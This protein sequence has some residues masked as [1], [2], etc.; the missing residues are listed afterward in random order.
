MLTAEKLATLPQRARENYPNTMFDVV[1][2]DGITIT[3]FSTFSYYEAKTYVKS[4][5]RSQTGALGNINN[6]ATFV[7][8]RLSISF[9][10]ITIEA[11]RT[12]MRLI[13]GKNE[14]TVTCYDPVSN[15]RKTNLMYFSPVDYPE[16]YQHNLEILGMLNFELELIGTNN[17]TTNVTVTYNANKP[18][19]ASGSVSNM[20]S[21]KTV[22]KNT[23]IL[24]GGTV[25]TLTGY[26]FVKWGVSASSPYFSYLNNEQYLI[27]DNV[28]LYAQWEV[29]A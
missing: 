10:Y 25:P 11:Y 18:S 15:T 17:E 23:T 7:T 1:E 13:A 22:A 20:P 8:P 14:F 3:S 16:I 26:R 19:G 4:P 29:S 12:I 27:Y 21:N 6:Y 5:S 2:I 9:K 28:T 24:I